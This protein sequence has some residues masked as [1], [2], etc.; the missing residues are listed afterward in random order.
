MVPPTVQVPKREGDI[1]SRRGRLEVPANPII[2]FITGDGVGA[3]ITPVM[4]Q[5][6]DSAVLK[7]Y[8]RQRKLEWMRIFA[9]EEVLKA[10]GMTM[11]ETEKLSLEEQQELHLPRETV[12]AIRK[13]VVAIKGPLTTP[14]GRGMRSLN[15]ALRQTLDLYA[16]VRPIRWYRGVPTP[17][18]KAEKLNVVIFR[19][20]TEDVYAG[21]E[22]NEETEE[23][24]RVRNF[25]TKE[26][27][28]TIREDSAIGVKTVSRT[29]TKRLVRA[30]INYSLKNKRKSLTLVHKGNIMKATEGA[31]RNWGYEV[32][33][34]E[35]REAIVTERE[36][37]PLHTKNSHPEMEYEE[38]IEDLRHNGWFGFKV[39]ETRSILNSLYE[40]HG[41]NK[42]YGKLLI[43][44]RI[45]DDMFQQILLEP[46]Q[47]DVIATLNLNG[48]Y[49]SE[50]C[51]AAVGGIGMAPGGNINYETGAA[52]FEAT[53]GT[54]PKLAGLNKANPSSL[55]LSAV[56][57]LKHIGWNEAAELLELALEKTIEERTVTG[58]LHVQ[59]ED[60]T[61]LTTSQF[62]QAIIINI[63]AQR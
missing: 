18:R 15:V 17:L 2:P 29:A 44:D 8:G 42:L 37:G 3:E 63:N 7:A 31:F 51:S 47:Y 59:I 25:L 57:M 39:E 36:Y 61:E 40:T 13:Y 48:D 1:R 24:R 53:H 46:N 43:K 28:A 23:A 5:V 26:M 56:M 30:S 50:A 38:M 35:F 34:E 33:T 21:I 19:E 12:E 16:C 45:A 10:R 32:A 62:G 9:G 27:G 55:I 4:R 52:L 49:L 20:N 58:D 60:S 41:K 54:A 22:W 6:V 11:E 14:V